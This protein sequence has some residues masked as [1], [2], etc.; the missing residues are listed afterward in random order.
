MSNALSSTN[1]FYQSDDAKYFLEGEEAQHCQKVMRMRSGDIIIV[2]NGRGRRNTVRLTET[3][4]KECHYEPLTSEVIEPG[5]V[6][7]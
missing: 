6:P 1:T 4:R 5:E 7:D 3:S 2:T